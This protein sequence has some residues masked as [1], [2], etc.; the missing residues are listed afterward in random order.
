MAEDALLKAIEEDAASEIE[1]LL[2][3]ARSAASG[4]IQRAREDARRTE[5]AEVA[6]LTASLEKKRETETALARARADALR[7]SARREAIEAVIK[8]AEDRFAERTD[9]GD[10]KAVING[11]LDELLKE[12][13]QA[14]FGA[15][16]ALLNPVDIGLVKRDGL[17]FR[18]DALV[19]LGV[20]LVSTDGAIR[21]ENTVGSRLK[22]A[23]RLLCAR[24]DRL[25]A[26]EGG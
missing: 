22:K 25:I 20:V 5:E 10:Y 1:R 17:E 8:E 7:L 6:R 9:R 23:E 18:P 26:G 12:W 13:D 14:A 11:F 4:I 15:P 3:D 21:F 2:S 16:T 19:K 24:L